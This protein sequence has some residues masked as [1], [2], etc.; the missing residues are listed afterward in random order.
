MFYAK[1]LTGLD[2]VMVYLGYRLVAKWV[3]LLSDGKG[4]PVI[5]SS[6]RPTSTAIP[7]CTKMTQLTGTRELLRRWSEWSVCVY[8]LLFASYPWHLFRCNTWPAIHERIANVTVQFLWFDMSM[9]RSN[10]PLFSA[11]AAM[12]WQL[13]CRCVV[14]SLCYFWPLFGGMK[15]TV[16][17]M[18]SYCFTFIISLED[19][20]YIKHHLGIF[21]SLNTSN[22]LV[23]WC[24]WSILDPPQP[25][26]PICCH[27]IIWIIY[28]SQILTRD[29]LHNLTKPRLIL[30][31]TVE[32]HTTLRLVVCCRVV[33]VF[34]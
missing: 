34:V 5:K 28:Y 25:G 30:Q 9:N 13:T 3:R 20:R 29:S 12:F 31:H 11:R 33:C 10:G 1:F 8:I 32:L 6:A 15:L 18:S 26:T 19:L 24:H 16:G 22:F 4:T 14:V 2:F 27:L 23:S 17:S 21:Q 7:Q